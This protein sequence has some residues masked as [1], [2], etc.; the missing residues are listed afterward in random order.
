MGGGKD[1]LYW[2]VLVKNTFIDWFLAKITFIDELALNITC[3]DG[4]L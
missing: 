3:I 4:F 2:W 1:Y